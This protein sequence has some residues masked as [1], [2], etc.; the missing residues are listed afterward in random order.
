MKSNQSKK[1]S[2]FAKKTKDYVKIL[3]VVICN[4]VCRRAYKVNVLFEV[5]L[6][7]IVG[8]ILCVYIVNLCRI[9]LFVSDEV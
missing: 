2:G 9:H 6:Y 3:S 1:T 5:V 8:N 7:V 4:W